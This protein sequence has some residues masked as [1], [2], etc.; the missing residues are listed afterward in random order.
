MSKDE[1]D[2]NA[3]AERTHRL[4]WGPTQE[5]ED[6]KDNFGYWHVRPVWAVK[7]PEPF[8]GLRCKDE[9]HAIDVCDQL[10]STL[11]RGSLPENHA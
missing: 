7:G 6:Y 4:R 2:I 10:N 9:Q 11:G 3:A 5:W 1:I 8:G